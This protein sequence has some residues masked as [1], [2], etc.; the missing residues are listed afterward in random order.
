MKKP[1]IDIT[2]FVNASTAFSNALAIAK[3]VEAQNEADREPYMY[4]VCRAGVIQHFEICYELSWKFMKR[5]L[6]KCN[7]D[8]V[9]GLSKKELFRLAQEKGLIN[10]FEKW[11][12]FASARNRTSHVYDEEVAEDVYFI[13]KES[14]PYMEKLM[15]ELE[16]RI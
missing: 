10:D 16:A 3:K 6:E 7:G 14:K 15:A 5:W 4:E 12:S 9:E 2:P 1:L 13:A 11:S 8:D